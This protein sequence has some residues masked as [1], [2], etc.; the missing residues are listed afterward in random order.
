MPGLHGIMSAKPKPKARQRAKRR[1]F[2]K[3]TTALKSKSPQTILLVDA[4]ENMPLLIESALKTLKPRPRIQFVNNS[5]HGQDYLFGRDEFC[6]RDAY[7]FPDLLLLDLKLPLVDG[8]QFLGWARSQ[9]EF[10]HLP[11][12][13]LSNSVN[14][15]HRTLAIKLGANFFLMKPFDANDLVPQVKTLLGIH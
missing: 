4:D 3:R 14:P 7:P 6:D 2:A 8:F 1:A 10:K 12:L 15:E 11:I 5:F 13:A 9:P